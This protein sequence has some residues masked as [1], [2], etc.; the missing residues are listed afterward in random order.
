M[1]QACGN[2]SWEAGS[3]LVDL[4]ELLEL[5]LHLEGSREPLPFLN[6]GVTC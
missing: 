1:L 4:Q 3:G 5:G 6:R 2:E